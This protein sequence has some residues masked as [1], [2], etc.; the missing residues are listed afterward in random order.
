MLLCCP[1]CDND[2][3][4]TEGGADV[5]ASGFSLEGFRESDGAWLVGARPEAFPAETRAWN[6]GR[7]EPLRSGGFKELLAEVPAL[8][9][10]S[11][12]HIK[13]CPGCGKVNAFTLTACNACGTDLQAV[14]ES[15]TPNLFVGMIFGIAKAPFP[16]RISLRSETPEIMV[17]DDP[18]AI[19]RAHM[20]G[21]PTNLYVKDFRT[22]LTS[23]KAGL[24]LLEKLDRAC[25]E[26][27]AAGPL[28]DITWRNQALS[29]EGN[30]LTLEALRYRVTRGFNLPPSQYQLHLQYVLPPLTPSHF[31]LWRRNLHFVR[32]RHFSYSYVEAAL[33]ALI[34][35]GKSL[36]YAQHMPASE[37]IATLKEFGV[38]YDIDYQQAREHL[39]TCNAFL[40]N[41]QLSDFDYVVRNEAL[42]D[43]SGTEV[44]FSTAAD[45]S[46]ASVK[47]FEEAD[48]LS[49]Q[50]YGRPYGE[51]NK[52]SG[53]Y[54]SYAPENPGILSEIA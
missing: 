30:K 1:A 52:P 10:Q 43:K 26:A 48:K 32:G 13:K 33:Q 27:L 20:L 41:F 24:E 53:V 15:K 16:L 29:P 3:A 50:S 7:P 9:E 47:S 39:Q 31:R 19:S 54:Y 5:A 49:L 12:N 17:F 8:E 35:C 46:A 40:A 22:L 44:C 6:C 21:M 37:L 51:D 28:N 23:P 45:G 4:A 11:Q 34:A 36:T 42:C 2:D 18:L 38:D 25:W 14:P